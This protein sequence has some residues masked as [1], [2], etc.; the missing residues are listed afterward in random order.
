MVLR[1]QIAK[2]S[3]YI[4]GLWFNARTSNLRAVFDDDLDQLIDS[5]GLRDQFESGNI[6][7]GFCNEV[8]TFD[9]LRAL[10]KIKDEIVVICDKA[11]CIDRI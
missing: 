9:N 5:L 6:R 11:Q 7:C 1:T 8:I 2:I 10:T 4:K 3:R